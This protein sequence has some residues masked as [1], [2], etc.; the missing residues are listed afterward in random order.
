MEDFLGITTPLQEVAYWYSE[1][2]DNRRQIWS[3]FHD[4]PTVMEALR[5][6][7][8]IPLSNDLSQMQ[9]KSDTLPFAASAISTP[10]SVSI[11]EAS[12]RHLDFLQESFIENGCF[13]V[14]LCNVFQAV[15]ENGKFIYTARVSYVA[16]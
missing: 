2:V 11:D 3:Y 9:S 8:P 13:E 15:G 6:I 12:H 10:S 14:V 1:N 4:D 16:V 5:F 7:E